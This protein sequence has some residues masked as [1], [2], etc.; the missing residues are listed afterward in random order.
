MRRLLIT[1]F[2]VARSAYGETFDGTVLRI[3][4]G[5]SLIV[6]FQGKQTRVR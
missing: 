5:D 2:L 6:V 1:L 3:V 4:D